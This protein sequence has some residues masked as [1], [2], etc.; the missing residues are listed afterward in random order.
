MFGSEPRGEARQRSVGGK[1]GAGLEAEVS[2]E[3]LAS[4]QAL[5]RNQKSGT[6]LVS[7][8]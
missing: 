8:A 4:N 6:G 1:D 7:K 2:S 5:E 3:R